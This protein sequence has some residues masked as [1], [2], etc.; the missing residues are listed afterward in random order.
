M[1]PLRVLVTGGGRGIG[2]AIALRFAREGAKVAIAARTSSELD[3]VVAEINAAGGQGRAQQMNVADHGSVEAAVWRAVEFTGGALDVLVN[4]AGVFDVKPIEQMDVATWKRAMEVNLNGPFFVTLEALDP[5]LAS[6][7]AHI[8][9]ISSI[10]GRRGFA[11]NVAYCTTKFGIRGFSAALREDLKAKGVRVTTVY[12]GP[13]DT[14]MLEKLP[15]TSDRSNMGRP[16]AVADAI[17]QAYAAPQSASVEDLE[18]P[19]ST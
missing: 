16:E 6:G 9:N 2:R 11:G 7:K 19:A 18:V 15:G 5:L 17:W 8:F 10:A 3:A 12:P 13:T 14:T 1:N 4:N